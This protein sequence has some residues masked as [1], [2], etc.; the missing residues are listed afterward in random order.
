MKRGFLQMRG[1]CPC[2]VCRA[3]SPHEDKGGFWRYDPLAL[4]PLGP[5]LCPSHDPYSQLLYSHGPLPCCADHHD[6]SSLLDFRSTLS[7][8]ISSTFRD[9]SHGTSTEHGP[10]TTVRRVLASSCARA[11]RLIESGMTS[12]AL[13]HDHGRVELRLDK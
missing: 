6:T 10:R 9:R 8:A 3:R 5:L 13:D 2:C 1:T 7:S 12:I 4:T 11:E